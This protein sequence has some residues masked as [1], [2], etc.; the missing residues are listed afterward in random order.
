MSE[1][2]RKIVEA[3]KTTPSP[4]A[5]LCA[6]WVSQVYQN[7]GLGY[8]GGNG[9]SMLD[10]RASSEDFSS[11]EP[12]EV[13][14][15]QYGDGSDGKLYGHVCIYIGNGQVMDNIGSIRTTDM[16]SWVEH[17]KNQGGWVKHGWLA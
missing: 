5:G 4:G 15:A 3:A 7:A 9:N 17:Y 14:S 16:S 2:G 10:G 8:P 6:M 1:K 11:I 12:G 13:I